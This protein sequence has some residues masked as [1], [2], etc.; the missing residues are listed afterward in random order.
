MRVSQHKSVSRFC[1]DV[2][3][4]AQIPVMYRGQQQEPAE[5]FG[6]FGVCQHS[7][8][9]SATFECLC[10]DEL[11]IFEVH[12]SDNSLRRATEELQAA[13]QGQ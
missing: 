9:S 8:G 1:R 7:P 4:K 13:S 2:A 5:S 12:A 3:L 10:R 11:E 6:I